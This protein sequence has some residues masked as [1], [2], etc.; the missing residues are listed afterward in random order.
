MNLTKIFLRVPLTPSYLRNHL[1]KVIQ[2]LS[3]GPYISIHSKFMVDK[4]TFPTR[5]LGYK[6]YLDLSNNKDKE[7]YLSYATNLYRDKI[8]NGYKFHRITG[9]NILCIHINKET[10]LKSKKSR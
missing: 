5:S 2:S 1:R 10:Y 9:L 7:N 6:C 3:Y 4:N 8:L